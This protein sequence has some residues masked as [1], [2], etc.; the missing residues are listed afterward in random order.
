MSEIYE[1]VLRRFSEKIKSTQEIKLYENSDK[2]AVIVDPRYDDLMEVVIRQH[3]FFL[4]P[5]GWN[6][7]VVSHKSY[8]DKICAV[9]PNCMFVGIDESLI[10]YK[11]GNPNMTLNSYNNIMLNIDFWK[12]LPYEN[13]L[14]FQ[15]DCFMYKMFDEKFLDCDYVGSRS[16]LCTLENNQEMYLMNG[17]LS[18]RKKT[19]M[20]D[21]LQHCSFEQIYEKID[22]K[23]ITNIK[24]L[25]NKSEDIYFSLVCPFLEKKMPPFD[26]IP[27]FSIERE[28]NID[29]AGHHGWNKSYHTEEQVLEIL[30]ANPN[31]KDLLENLSA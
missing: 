14:I 15:K 10:F 27:F 17:G 16:P 9:F 21:C 23:K 6:L 12:I 8:E 26:E 31:Y 3:M 22:M 4:N 13:I 28:Y 5:C 20:I 30:S 29:A 2:I 18:F 25:F 11:D 1:K 24:H 7:M 19:A